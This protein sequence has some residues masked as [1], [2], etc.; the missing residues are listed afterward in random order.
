MGEYPGADAAEPR[1]DQMTNLYLAAYGGGWW[2]GA[3]VLE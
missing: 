2:D 3:L 1:V